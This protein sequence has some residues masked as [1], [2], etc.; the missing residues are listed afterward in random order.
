M[1]ILSSELFL[2]KIKNFV[3][4]KEE[5]EKSTNIVQDMNILIL[6]INRS[7][8]KLSNDRKDEN[9]ITKPDNLEEFYRTCCPTG[10]CIFFSS[11]N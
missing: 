2:Y 10:E 6:V 3:E 1:T 8:Q 9:N 7:R 5:I 11:V 4:F